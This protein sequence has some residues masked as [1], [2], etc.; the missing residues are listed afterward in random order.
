MINEK[1]AI[2]LP[3]EAMFCLGRKTVGTPFPL[4]FPFLTM[5][6]AVNHPKDDHEYSARVEIT[7]DSIC[8]FIMMS[9][10]DGLCWLWS[11]GSQRHV[12]LRMWGVIMNSLWGVIGELWKE[13]ARPASTADSTCT[14]VWELTRHRIHHSLTRNPISHPTPMI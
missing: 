1:L 3:C 4:F 14:C 9:C 6:P 13:R 7:T 2:T 12:W 5:R 11:A 8:I 10:Q